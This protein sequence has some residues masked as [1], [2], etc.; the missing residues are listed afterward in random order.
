MKGM[1]I[2]EALDFIDG[3]YINEAKTNEYISEIKKEEKRFKIPLANKKWLSPV[4]AILAVVILSLHFLLGGQGY[5]FFGGVKALA[6]AEYPV[7]TAFPT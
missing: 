6:S 3:K 7:M 2:L 1:E 4:A 5:A